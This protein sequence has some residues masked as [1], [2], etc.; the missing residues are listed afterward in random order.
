MPSP[1]LH[2]PADLDLD[3]SNELT[4][5]LRYPGSVT[6]EQTFG[7]RISEIDIGGDLE[8]RLTTVHG[9]CR[10]GGSLRLSGNVD[11][12]HLHGAVVV[13]EGSSIRARS[14]SAS[15]RIII[16]PGELK[17]DVI[18]APYIE[19]HPEATG[20]VT[21]I[22][23]HNQRGLT[24]IKGGFSLNEYE[25]L[26]GDADA[27]LAQRGV[28]RLPGEQAPTLD[29]DLIEPIEDEDSEDAEVVVGVDEIATRRHSME[30]S[31]Q[32]QQQGYPSTASPGPVD[33]FEEIEPELELEP[34]IAE[35]PP[36]AQIQMLQ[37][38]PD[39][40][41]FE[42]L[43]AV[44]TVV[45]PPD[46]PELELELEE[47][48]DDLDSVE[49]QAIEELDDDFD[50]VEPEPLEDDLQTEEIV[51]FEES[52]DDLD[53]VDPVELG[54]ELELIR[55]GEGEPSALGDPDRITNTPHA[56]P[57]RA[58]TPMVNPPR[59]R[60]PPSPEVE[61]WASSIRT[62]ISELRACFD[63]PPQPIEGLLQAAEEGPEAVE[64]LYIPLWLDLLRHHRQRQAPVSPRVAHGFRVLNDLILAGP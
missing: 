49:P 44:E 24:K 34:E 2:I 19:I 52:E 57:P 27:F 28:A 55:D 47:I 53:T 6:L 45:A 43:D 12:V 59:E 13:I 35:F 39:L 15:E 20:R 38:Q 58:P 46:V 5:D 37:D 29:L 60:R 33:T 14:I 56:L 32:R 21:V 40:N 36:G 17:V 50:T 18:I 3:L 23:S 54:L 63:T 1:P 31:Q 51:D 62:Q 11:A 10:A 64:Q 8:L 42:E 4:I 16:G 9:T 25:D 41:E 22:E 26:F 61:A 30:P 48:V 7:R